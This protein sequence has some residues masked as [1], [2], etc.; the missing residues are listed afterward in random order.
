MH[1][2]TVQGRDYLYHKVS[3]VSKSLGLRTGETQRVYDSFVAGRDALKARLAQLDKAIRDAAPVDRAMGLGRVPTTVAKIIRKLDDHDFLSHGISIVGTNA[4]FAYERMAGGH[5][6][7]GLLA[8]GDVDLL[9]DARQR[10][11]LV[12]PSQ[13]SDGLSAILRQVD[14]SF[15]AVAPGAFRAVNDSGL[16]V[17]LIQPMPKSPSQ[18]RSPARVGDSDDLTAIEIEGLQWLQNA[19][20]HEVVAID[21][22]GF[23][24]MLAVP[25]PR[26]FALHKLW[27][28]ERPDRDPLKARRDRAQAQAIA[29]IIKRY[30]PDLSFDDASLTA[31][32]LE[33]TRRAVELTASTDDSTAD[34]WR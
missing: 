15:S 20:Q 27:V 14:K 4:L 12:S 9:I 34:D 29:T 16:T 33:L 31:V 30:L 3:G 28:S 18:Q 25:D 13:T 23:P 8:T 2:K 26:A 21:E 6:E 22:R 19:P 5:F 11:R 17:D 32:P 24:L 1:W 10:L 7:G